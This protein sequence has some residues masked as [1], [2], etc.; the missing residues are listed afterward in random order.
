MVRTETKTE[1]VKS[2]FDRNISS[3]W[4]DTGR[5]IS[6]KSGFNRGDEETGVWNKIYQQRYIDTIQRNYS[7]GIIT[8]VKDHKGSTSYKDPWKVLDGGNRMRAI[9]DFLQDK[10]VNLIDNKKFSQLSAEQR[11]KFYNTL[12]SVEEVTIERND[13]EDTI[14]I[15]FIRLNTQINKLSKG[16][17]YKAHGHRGDIWQIEMAKKIVGDSWTSTFND[18]IKVE[19]EYYD[20][21]K[22]LYIDISLIREYWCKIFGQLGETRRCDSLAMIIGFII[23]ANTSNFTLFDK[24]YN[25]LKKHLSKSNEKPKDIDYEKIY[26]K[27]WIL[28]DFI[29]DINDKSIFGKPVKGVPPQTKIAPVWKRIC[30]GTFSSSDA[31]IM[32]AFYNSLND[33]EEGAK[34][35][36]LDLFKGSNGETGPTKVQ[37]IIDYIIC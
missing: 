2:L 25:K 6:V 34:D 23:S 21:D 20:E 15:M 35:H 1:T 16:E 29:N 19:M 10:F 32:T 8:L 12:I 3:E 14:A 27:L 4:K 11:W 28:L 36:Y 5:A 17:L 26:S 9:R 18:D 7:K 24:R 30:E 13:P 33:N 22:N 37:K 31:N